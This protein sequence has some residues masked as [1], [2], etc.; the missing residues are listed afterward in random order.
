MSYVLSLLSSARGEGGSITPLQRPADALAPWG[1]LELAPEPETGLSELSAPVASTA[2]MASAR[3]HPPPLESAA[4]SPLSELPAASTTHAEAP[5]RREQHGAQTRAGATREIAP[6]APRPPAEI[7]HH[8][9]EVVRELSREPVLAPSTTV[10]IT[11]VERAAPPA[12]MAGPP[13]ARRPRELPLPTPRAPAPVEPARPVAAARVQPPRPRPA[14]P[15]EDLPAKRRTQVA[16]VARAAPGASMP[17][18]VAQPATTLH[19]HIGRIVVRAAQAASG[20]TAARAQP[21]ATRAMSLSD[22]LAR[23]ERGPR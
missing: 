20:E 13:P 14:A 9:R 2:R 19:V 8:T 21:A 22:Y 11:R 4:S 17:A 6:A 16:P 23:R 3:A 1:E 12:P 5:Q 7:V 18:Q 15:G 10:E